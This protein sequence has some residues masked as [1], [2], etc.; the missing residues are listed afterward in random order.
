MAKGGVR[1][2]SREDKPTSSERAGSAPTQTIW[3][4]NVHNRDAITGEDVEVGEGAAA[5]LA[6]SPGLSL[7]PSRK[8]NPNGNSN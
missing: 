8:K 3:R 7:S 6:D 5:P 2:L 4:E 1:V